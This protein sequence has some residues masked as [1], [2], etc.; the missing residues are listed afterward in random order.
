MIKDVRRAGTI[1]QE[2]TRMSGC[3]GEFGVTI[4]ERR[5]ATKVAAQ[6]VSSSTKSASKSVCRKGLEAKL[7]F[8]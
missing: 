6:V 4:K 7:S 8:I 5:I 3:Q 1:I 2:R